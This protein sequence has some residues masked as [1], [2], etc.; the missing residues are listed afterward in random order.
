[1]EE[2]SNGSHLGFIRAPQSTYVPNL[3][4]MKGKNC[5]WLGIYSENT[6]CCDAIVNWNVLLPRWNG[7]RIED[8]KC[9][10]IAVGDRFGFK[11]NTEKKTCEVFHNGKSL[12]VVFKDLP[13]EISPAISS[14]SKSHNSILL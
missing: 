12:G 6:W 1:M 4:T 5:K 2:Y 10:K 14:T 8:L 13:T 3:A 9:V 7:R 11:I